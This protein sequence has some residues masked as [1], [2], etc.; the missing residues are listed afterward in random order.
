MG[1]L[2]LRHHQIKETRSVAPDEPQKFTAAVR[3]R[4]EVRD[5]F[6]TRGVND[7]FSGGE[8]NRME[9]LQLAGL[10]PKIAVPDEIDSGL[11]VDALARAENMPWDFKG[12]DCLPPDYR[13][14][15]V[16][17]SRGGAD[18][19]EVQGVPG[20]HVARRGLH[21]KAGHGKAND[22]EASESHGFLRRM[23]KSSRK[24]RSET[25]RPTHETR[26]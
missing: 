25:A 4:L 7:D 15:L 6:L 18:A 10:R 9:T 2:A 26:P 22:C 12:A 1:E 5:E 21:G 3:S 19:D 16:S 23:R 24:A 20:R 17:L 11:D 13:K 8:Q 14:C